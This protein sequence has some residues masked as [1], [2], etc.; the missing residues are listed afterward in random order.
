MSQ[1]VFKKTQRALVLSKMFLHTLPVRRFTVAEYH[2]MGEVGILGED[3][4]VELLDGWIVTWIVNLM[5]NMIEVYRAP[6]MLANGVPGYRSRTDFHPG[7]PIRPEAFP[8]LAIKLPI[9]LGV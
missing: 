3:E 7:E 2:R 8:D 6:L 4:R 1:T 5:A 9:P